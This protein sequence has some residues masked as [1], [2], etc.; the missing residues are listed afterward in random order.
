[1]IDLHS[2]CLPAID[3]G[4]ENVKTSLRMLSQSFYQGVKTCVMTP[5]CVLH[6]QDKID[7][8]LKARKESFFELQQKIE[9]TGVLTPKL[10]LGAEVYFDNDISRYD[11]IEKLCIEGTNVLLVEFP[12][13]SISR[14]SSEWLYSLTIKGIQP[15]IAHID[16]YSCFNAL[17]DDFSDL[18]LIYQV[19]AENF[20]S[21]SGRSRLSKIFKND[22]IFVVSSDMHNLKDRPCNMKSAYERCLKKYGTV[23]SNKLFNNN[24]LEILGLTE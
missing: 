3:D 2:H 12:M 24:A 21:F 15:L 17:M 5:H 22:K 20:L 6:S 23:F 4:A 7:N 10:L 18:D 19:N 16:R 8:F 11:G 1:M 13:G 9:E 14:K